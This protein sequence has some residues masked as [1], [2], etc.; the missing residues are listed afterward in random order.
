MPNPE[1]TISELATLLDAMSDVLTLERNALEQRDADQL[2]QCSEQKDHICKQLAQARF[3][4]DLTSEIGKLPPEERD[5]C[6]LLHRREFDRLIE[7]RDLNLV[8]GKILNRS[9]HS[10]RELLNILSGRSQHGLYGESGQPKNDSDPNR[11]AIA[12]A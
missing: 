11:G 7:L 3:G 4:D 12:R 8:N 2:A 6:E 5:K 10:V 1:A 9:Q